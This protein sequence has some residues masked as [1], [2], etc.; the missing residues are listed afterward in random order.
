MRRLVE[1]PHAD[2]VDQADL[3]GAA[4]ERRDRDVAFAAVAVDVPERALAERVGHEAP[5][6]HARRRREGLELG[7]ALQFV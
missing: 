6:A 2:P 7:L 1:V 3:R 5:A 4:A